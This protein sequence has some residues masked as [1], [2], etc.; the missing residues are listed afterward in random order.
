MTDE[1]IQQNDTVENTQQTTETETQADP[2]ADILSKFKIEETA[3]QFESQPQQRVEQPATQE[4]PKP[5]IP[6]P[7]D[8]DNFRNYM[9]Q[10]AQGTTALQNQ[11]KSVLDNFGRMAAEQAQQK[12]ESDIKAAVKEIDDVAGIGKPKLVEAYLDAKVRE[13]SRLRTIWNNRNKNPEA[14]KEALKHVGKEMAN[15]FSVRVDP[16]LVESQKARRAA[17]SQSPTTRNETNEEAM[18]SQIQKVGFDAF[19]QSL[20]GDMN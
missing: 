3:Q 7:Y 11:L 19:W 16:K 2:I 5:N 18:E 12:L 20:K 14:Y 13:D 10:Q 9:A 15:E 6:D 17:Q 4:A 1:T 8:T